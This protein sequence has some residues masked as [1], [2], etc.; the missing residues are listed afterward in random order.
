[1]CVYRLDGADLRVGWGIEHPML[2]KNGITDACSTADCCPLLSIVDN[3]PQMLSQTCPRHSPNNAPDISHMMPQIMPPYMPQ[4]MPQMMPQTPLLWASHCGANN[5]LSFASHLSVWL[6]WRGL[7][8]ISFFFHLW[9]W[10]FIAHWKYIYFIF[11]YWKYIYM[12]LKV[13]S[14]AN[15]DCVQRLQLV[16]IIQL[17]LISWSHLR[18]SKTVIWRKIGKP[19]FCTIFNQHQK[20]IFDYLCT[21]VCNDFETCNHCTFQKL[22]FLLLLQQKIWRF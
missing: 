22:S 17:F 10:F 15:A 2:L 18:L 1:M 9:W 11:I 16:E 20:L 3:M 8:L 7:F 12:D 14:R 6:G 5:R 13:Q 19:G 21:Q 4:T